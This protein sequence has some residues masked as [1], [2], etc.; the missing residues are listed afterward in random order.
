MKRECEQ[1]H[2]TIVRDVIDLVSSVKDFD[3]VEWLSNRHNT[4]SIAKR[5]SNFILV[6]PVIVSSNMSISTAITISK[7]IER[8][9]VSLLQ[10]LFSSVQY[11]NS[12][13]LQDYLDQFHKNLN[14]KDK[15]DLDDFMDLMDS[16]AEGGI[17]EI[18]D[19][20]IYEAV[21][22]DMQNINHILD[23]EFNPTSLNDYKSVRN[24][25]GESSI[26]LEK[27][28]TYKG[29]KHVY[30]DDLS[31]SRNYQAGSRQ[32]D[33]DDYHVDNS[34]NNSGNRFFNT[35][36]TNNYRSDGGNRTNAGIKDLSDYFNKQLLPSDI[37]KANELMPTTMLVNFTTVKDNNKI[38]TT[39]IIGVKAKLYPVDSME[40]VSR[41]SSK[42]KEK[43]GLF[44]LIRAT[45]REI[46]FFK[47]LAFAIE[48]AKADAIYMAK[49]S[50]NAKMFRV[51]ERRAT[52]HRF[53]SLIKKNDASPITSLVLSQDD[54][55]YL[56]KYNDL[57]M[58]KSFNAR[59]ILEA[60]NLMDIIIVDESLEI[61]KF[62]FDDGDGVYETLTFDALEKESNDNGY[63]KVINLMSRVNR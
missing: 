14:L 12:A 41:L 32:F 31:Q 61:A 47:D 43:N 4:G 2:E 13:D 23:T 11:N 56:K 54:V 58:E 26:M 28:T 38:N 34:I 16:L 1:L 25:Y 37:K 53:L 60:Y 46:S 63:K 57:D 50:N 36:T 7:A 20:D 3:E 55:E 29:G 9:C 18:T 51:L 49:D 21:K 48:K 8:K 39:G 17:I 33:G 44:N 30:G 40:L 52:K 42:S 19:T 45:T 15:M 22:E 35:S 59:T 27:K 10:I 5:A 62:M 24:I 6:F